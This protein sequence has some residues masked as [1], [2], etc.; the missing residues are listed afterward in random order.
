MVA[1][2]TT[3]QIPQPPRLQCN[4]DGSIDRKQLDAYFRSLAQIPNNISLQILNLTPEQELALALIIE[5]IESAVDP[6]TTKPFSERLKSLELDLKYRMRELS[7]DLEEYLKIKVVEILLGLIEALGIPNPFTTPIPFLGRAEDGTDPLIIDLFTK[8][9]QKIVKEAAERD[10][11][12]VKKFFADLES[13][14]NG[15]LGVKSPDMEKEETWHKIKNW[16]SQKLNEFIG[17]VAKAIANAL[18]RIPII[19]EPIYKLVIGATDPT[20]PIEEQFDALVK[21]YKKDIK[22]GIDKVLSGEA[23]ENAGEQLLQEVIDRIL[24]IPIPL[25]GTVRDYV[26]VDIKGKGIVMSEMNFHDVEDKFKELIQKARRFFE[27]DLLVKIYGI[28]DKAPKFILERFPIVGQIYKALKTVVDILSGKNPLTD[29]DILN[30]IF[31]VAFGLLDTVV[32]R[33]SPSINIEFIE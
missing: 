31:P 9:G 21:Q 13:V 30:I 17:N 18:R 24:D 12:R 20:V 1:V 25:L 4:P 3:I 16:F 8:D 15:D 11:E 27:G 22:E 19:G 23:L 14:F 6:V 28:I 7:K 10:I 33:L 29:C 32:A 26:D 5:I 2:A